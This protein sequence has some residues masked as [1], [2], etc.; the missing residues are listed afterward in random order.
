MVILCL[1][2]LFINSDFMHNCSGGVGPKFHVS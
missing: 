1:S 2:E